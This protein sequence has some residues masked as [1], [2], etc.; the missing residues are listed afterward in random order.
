MSR[1]FFSANSDTWEVRGSRSANR[2]YGVRCSRYR[3]QNAAFTI[4]GCC[5]AS[6]PLRRFVAGLKR[7][8]P[9][10]GTEEI[11]IPTLFRKWRERRV[12]H[13]RLRSQAEFYV[14]LGLG[15]VTGPDIELLRLDYPLFQSRTP[16]LQFI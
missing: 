13:P 6:K 8:S 2:R 11:K 7:L 4:L 10:R 12:G 5:F 9:Q 14:Q 15:V 16:E 3:G 1:C